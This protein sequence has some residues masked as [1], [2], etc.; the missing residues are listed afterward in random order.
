MCGD[1][2]SVDRV[3][4]KP[5]IELNA[6]DAYHKVI[7]TG[8]RDTEK[9]KDMLEALKRFIDQENPAGSTLAHAALCGAL[10]ASKYQLPP[11]IT[12]TAVSAGP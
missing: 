8:L 7:I 11:R 6:K 4:S 2:A 12:C 9:P 10:L 1:Q 5:I 3:L